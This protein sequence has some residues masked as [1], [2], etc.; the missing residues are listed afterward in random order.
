MLNGIWSLLVFRFWFL[1]MSQRNQLLIIQLSQLLENSLSQDEFKKLLVALDKLPRFL[2]DKPVGS[3]CYEML[4]K[5][6]DSTRIRINHDKKADVNILLYALGVINRSDIVQEAE[7]LLGLAT[8]PPI[9]TS[10]DVGN[11]F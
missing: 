3:A 10:Q 1:Q 5:L 8:E 2:Q 4:G 6:L 9:P 11:K 7:K